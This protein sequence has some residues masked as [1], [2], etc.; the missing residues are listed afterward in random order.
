VNRPL[1]RVLVMVQPVDPRS[2]DPKWYQ[3]AEQIR[4]QIISGRWE[5]GHHLPGNEDLAHETDT[6]VPTVRRALRSLALEELI[7]TE[8]GVR[9]QV[10]APR[11]RRVENVKPGD[12]IKYRPATPDEQRQHGLGEGADVAEVTGVDGTVRVFP[13]RGVEF[14]VDGDG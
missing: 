3:V 11:E 13:P 4:N 10:A 5:P 6:S 9:A 7:V 1:P 2:R 8:Q 14:V 12:R